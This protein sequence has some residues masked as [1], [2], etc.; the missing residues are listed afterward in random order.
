MASWEQATEQIA[1][2]DI[3]TFEDLTF[4]DVGEVAP[5][6]WEPATME[7]FPPLQLRHV[8]RGAVIIGIHKNFFFSTR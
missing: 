2:S 8:V 4:D 7:D 3:E 5:K 1:P 6:E